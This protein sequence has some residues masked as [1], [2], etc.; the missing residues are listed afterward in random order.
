MHQALLLAKA[1][2]PEPGGGTL[3]LIDFSEPVQDNHGATRGVLGAHVNWNWAAGVLQT[4]QP[5]NAAQM[6]L[7]ILIVNRDNTIIHPQKAGVSAVLPASLNTQLNFSQDVWSDGV[8]YVS[9]TVPI[10]DGSPERTMGWRI[11]V[12]QP[13]EEAFYKLREIQEVLLVT[14]L[15]SGTVFL[16]L[17]WWGAVL[18][19]R[20]LKELALHARSIEQGDETKPL[21]ATSSARELHD[22][23]QALQGMANTLLQRKNALAQ[24]NAVLEQTVAE[25]T[26][27]LQR[28]NQELHELSRHDALTG[29]FNRLA[30]KERLYAEFARMKRAQTPYAVLMMDIDYFKRV[31]D[32][33]GHDTG[34]KVLQAVSR[35][36]QTQLRETDFLARFGGEEF[37]AL[38]PNIGL[39]SAGEVAEKLR[40]AVAL[41]PSATG[42]PITLS[43]GLAMASTKDAS[44]D[45]AVQ[46]ADGF[47][48]RAKN[49]GRNRVATNEPA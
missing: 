17:V 47:L 13:V 31:N 33:Y 11:V 24:S 35:V 6:R 26:A 5:S 27:A 12:R 7:E 39:Q 43:I 42:H 2:P 19:S 44:E 3:Q 23:V 30:A 45:D 21:T 20:P 32:T 28:S 10:L 8:N 15:I 36:L 37:I 48:Y 46:R 18:I 4:M 14:A 25:R 1:L 29:V 9:S 22:L 38:L 40:A 49:A 41:A 16:A 34:D